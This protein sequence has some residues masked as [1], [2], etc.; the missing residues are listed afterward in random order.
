MGLT[1]PQK[2]TNRGIYWL[3]DG[4]SACFS[5]WCDVGPVFPGETLTVSF[6]PLLNGEQVPVETPGGESLALEA[7]AADAEGPV[8]LPFCLPASSIPVGSH[9]FTLVG[10]VEGYGPIPITLGVGATLIRGSRCPLAIPETPLE[11]VQEEPE[12]WSPR[13]VDPDTGRPLGALRT[14]LAGAL[15]MRLELDGFSASRPVPGLLAALVDRR[16]VS[17]AGGRDV[18]RVELPGE[19]LFGTVTTSLEDLPMDSGTHWVHL[20]QLLGWGGWSDFATGESPVIFVGEV[21]AMPYAVE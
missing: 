17:F 20:V 4:E 3:N 9:L 16:Q 10:F 21:M 19:G 12:G 8:E 5:A 7:T 6:I 2:R 13:A 15:A 14:D 11:Q 1:F 18:L